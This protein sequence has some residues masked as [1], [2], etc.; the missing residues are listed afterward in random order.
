MKKIGVPT[1]LIF[2]YIST[3]IVGYLG[4]ADKVHTQ[5]VFLSLLNLT[6]LNYLWNL[7]DGIFNSLKKT[8]NKLPVF[9]FFIFFCWT[10]IAIIPSI[11]IQE[12]LIQLSSYFT[13]LVS[14]IILIILFGQV[15]NIGNL[16]QF[17]IIFLSIVEVTTS[18]IPYISDINKLGQPIPRS[19]YYRGITGSVNILAFSLLIKLPFMFYYIINTKHKLFKSLV[20]VSMIFVIVQVTKTRSA[21]L[22][23][24]LLQFIFL[25]F[26]FLYFYKIRNFNLFKTSYSLVPVLVP[27]ILVLATDNYLSNKFDSEVTLT[28]RISSINTEDASTNS[29]LRYYKDAFETI[30]EKPIFGIG[31][32]NWEIYSVKK[33]ANFMDGY[34]VPYHVHNDYLE[35]A[36]ESG[37]IASMLYF[38]MIFYIVFILLRKILQK[39]RLSKNFLLEASIFLAITMYL[40]DAVFN[41][42]TARIIQQM[43]LLFLIAIT[44]TLFYSD[45]KEIK[46]NYNKI[47]ITFLLLLIPFS[48]YSTLRV[49]K[50][51]KEQ[52]KLLAFFNFSRMEA[53][54][55]EI[56]SYEMNYPN[57]T[58][59]ALPL[60]GVKGV[61]YFKNGEYEKAIKLFEESRKYN[62]F[63]YL[64]ETYKGMSYLYLNELD[65]ARYYTEIAAKKIPGNL[66]HM[67]HY[68]DVL[69]AFKDSA[70]IKSEFEKIP[71]KSNKHNEVY[72][73][74]MANTLDPSNRS[75]ADLDKY[76]ITIQSAYS[77]ISK[78]GIYQIKVGYEDMM[79][80]AS[81]HKLGEYYFEQKNFKSALSNFLES[82]RLNPYELPYQENLA[83]TYLQLNNNSEAISTIN[84]MEKNSDLSSK[85][86][87]IRA[88][89]YL[90]LNDNING[91]KDLQEVFKE[92]LVNDLVFQNFCS[93]NKEN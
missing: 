22:A 84:E 7:S 18:L 53:V 27:L 47:I 54:A 10:A 74:A 80:A 4:A 70:A 50:S 60:K 73:V 63:I 68:F 81:F 5:L 48:T 15:K 9:L 2:L 1:I 59:T 39:I 20:T 78:K 64:S 76:D 71:N 86:I 91:C 67:A 66:L 19:L 46:I 23:L 77:D 87:Y 41:F 79:R 93:V 26:S 85:A 69:T 44:V 56:E 62:P 49:Y 92:G 11:N 83:N 34:I 35:I 51:S 25:F 55:D 89:A 14:L 17:I 12:S 31:T 82:S 43:N 42:P 45:I 52:Q 40:I 37:I 33:E 21:F 75:Y 72:L 29:R 3:G 61:Y 30:L 36:A 16:I 65:S 32:G 57:L 88:L 8:L 58:V 38:F 28:S 90:A 6:S 24:L 13:Q